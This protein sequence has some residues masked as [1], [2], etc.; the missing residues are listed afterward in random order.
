MFSVS[1]FL[2]LSIIT[3]FLRLHRCAKPCLLPSASPTNGSYTALWRAMTLTITPFQSILTSA[4]P[5]DTSRGPSSRR[6]QL[7]LAML[8]RKT[9]SFGKSTCL[10][11]RHNRSGLR[12][13]P[14]AKSL[15]RER[16][17]KPAGV[18]SHPNIASTSSS[19]VRLVSSMTSLLTNSWSLTWNYLPIN[20]ELIPVVQHQH[21][22]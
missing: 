18:L 3:F 21:W 4:R 8:M 13:S 17:L 15:A 12:N 16:K 10:L 7:L 5:L 1:R 6:I 19:R 2:S 22:N 20:Y 14:R 11:L 9:S